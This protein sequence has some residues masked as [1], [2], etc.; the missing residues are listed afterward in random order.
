M[1]PFLELV[2]A[3]YA[4]FVGALIFAQVQCALGSKTHPDA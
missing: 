3:G 4:V 1:T 2:L